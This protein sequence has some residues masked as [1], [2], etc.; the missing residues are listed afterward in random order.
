MDNIVKFP[1]VSP[2][3]L[4][5]EELEN[6]RKEILAAKGAVFETLQELLTKHRET[7]NIESILS[8]VEFKNGDRLTLITPTEDTDSLIA[9]VERIKFMLITESTEWIDA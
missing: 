4:S 8:F 2:Q 7:G 5:T 3:S 6:E 9:T 1:G